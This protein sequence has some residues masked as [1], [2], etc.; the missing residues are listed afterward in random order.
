MGHY[1][2]LFINKVWSFLFFTLPKMFCTHQGVLTW[3]TPIETEVKWHS[4]VDIHGVESGSILVKRRWLSFHKDCCDSRLPPLFNISF[5]YTQG[6][7]AICYWAE[8]GQEAVTDWCQSLPGPSTSGRT[9]SQV[10]LGVFLPSTCPR[11]FHAQ[12]AS[13]TCFSKAAAFTVEKS[14]GDFTTYVI[15]KGLLEI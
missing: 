13:H 7:T 10:H 15:R 6:E 11:S 1:E 5:F 2:L 14:Y 8:S 12:H 4:L 3:P 9:E